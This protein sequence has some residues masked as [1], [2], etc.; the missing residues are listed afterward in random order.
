M[1]ESGIKDAGEQFA[2]TAGNGCWT[3]VCWILFRSPLVQR[4]DIGRLPRGW[5]GRHGI[6]S[7][8]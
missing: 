2:K 5:E 6:Y 7:V 4:C 3:V 1:R 8:E